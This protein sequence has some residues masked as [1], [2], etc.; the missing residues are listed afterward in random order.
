MKILNRN[1]KV[2]GR[3][4]QDGNKPFNYRYIGCNN[5]TFPVHANDLAAACARVCKF[6][7]EGYFYLLFT[8]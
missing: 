4:E 3:V 8:I 2:I 6:F 5:I 1:N 7:G